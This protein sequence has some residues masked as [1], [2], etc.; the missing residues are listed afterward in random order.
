MAEMKECFGLEL[1]NRFFSG[2]M[3]AAADDPAERQRLREQC[4][5]CPDFEHCYQVLD[6]VYKL[7]LAEGA[8]R[9]SATPSRLG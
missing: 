5:N 2:G 3:G 8:K 4:Y 6:L 1:A 7:R 9:S